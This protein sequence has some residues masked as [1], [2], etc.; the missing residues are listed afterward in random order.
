MRC[1]SGL[2]VQW[3]GV[4][5]EITSGRLAALHSASVHRPLTASLWDGTDGLARRGQGRVL[6][7]VGNG[8]TTRPLV[9]VEMEWAT[10]SSAVALWP[11]WRRRWPH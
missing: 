4:V 8:S 11:S 3:R 6:S 10:Q 5:S 1:G 7:G 9:G 2:V